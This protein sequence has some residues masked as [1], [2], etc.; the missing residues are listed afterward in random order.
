MLIKFLYKW[1]KAYSLW[2]LEPEQTGFAT[3][4]TVQGNKEINI[5]Y[6]YSCYKMSINAVSKLYKIN[7]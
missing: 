5:N 1:L 7:H 6:C 3:Q 4:A 2:E